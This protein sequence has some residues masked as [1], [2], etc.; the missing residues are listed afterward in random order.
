MTVKKTRAKK[1]LKTAV[2][3]PAMPQITDAD[4]YTSLQGMIWP[5]RGLC[6]EA[7]L[8]FRVHHAAGHSESQSNIEFRPGGGARLDTYFNLFNFG[9]WVK[10]CDLAD[11]SLALWGTGRFEVSVFMA[12]P[13]RSWERIYR[14]IHDLQAASPTRIDLSH[15]SDVA[16]RGVM[17]FEVT[18]LSDATLLDAAWQSRQA[19]LRT[20]DIALSVTTFKR[21]EAVHST[22]TRFESFMKT[23]ALR[24]HLHMIVVDNGQSAGLQSSQNVTAIDNE[25]L[26][27]SGGFARGLLAA[28][29][30]GASHCLFMDDDAASHMASYERTWMFLAYASDPATA[31]SGAIA[32][33]AHRWSV[34]ENGAVYDRRCWPLFIGTDLRNIGQLLEMEVQSTKAPP[35]GYYGGWWYFAFPIDQVKHMP[36][37]F[38]VRGDDISFSLVHDFKIVTLPGVMSF[39]DA[40]FSDKQ[41]AQTLYLDLRGH[42][43]HHLSMPDLEIGRWATLRIVYWFYAR[44][45]ITHHYGTMQ[46]LNQSFEDMMAGPEFFAKNADMS[47]RR[48]EIK[49]MMKGEAWEPYPGEPPQVKIR[50]DPRKRWVRGLMKLTLNGFLFPFFSASGNQIVLDAEGRNHIPNA[51]GASHIFI[52]DAKGKKAYSVHSS[53][54]STIKQGLRLLRNS[55]RFLLNYEKILQ[56]WRQG[57]GEVTSESFW[58]DLLKLTPKG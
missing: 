55:L 9:K 20:P 2:E 48:G 54:K 49:E 15:F 34:W 21:E 10:Y 14:D 39:Q 19:R 47:V 32:N 57:Y 35:E 40:D 56:R 31:V 7:D 6:S 11:L 26:G 29:E 12:I 1:Q 24:D 38:F 37:P 53:K 8:Y 43:A 42:L 36:F 3:V 50:F 23:S 18:A 58:K 13:E 22:V 46:A 45:M 51:L 52:Y 28:R 25:N 33:A 4:G 17:Y 5:E 27:G 30:R 44:A 16:D 41:S